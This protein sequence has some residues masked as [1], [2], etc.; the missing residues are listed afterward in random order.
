[1]NAHD[2]SRAQPL[3]HLP[4]RNQ[5]HV[6]EIADQLWLGFNNRKNH[7]LPDAICLGGGD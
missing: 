3:K 7:S 1:M 4:G 5:L 6:I 2:K